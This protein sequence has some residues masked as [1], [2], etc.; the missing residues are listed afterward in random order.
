MTFNFSPVD[1][2]VPFDNVGNG[3][4]SDNVH[5]AIIEAKDT[6]E[7]KQRLTIPLINNSTITNGNWITYS[8][9]LAN[10]RILLPLAMALKNISWVNNN[11]NL[12]AFTLEI[13]KNGQ[14]NPTNLIYT[15]TPTAG[16]R[17]AG[18][19]YFSFPSALNF[20]AGDSLYIKYVKPSGTSLS[21][22]CLTLYLQLL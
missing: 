13:Y 16:E 15:Y 4:V 17:T 21:D 2:S 14:V 7:G 20:A 11:T 22:L 5:D 3:F 18:Y 19:G 9:L 12:G 10:P 1:Y 8:E 6:A